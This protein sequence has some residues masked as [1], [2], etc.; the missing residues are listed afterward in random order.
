LY[1]NRPVNQKTEKRYQATTSSFF[2]KIDI[3][4]SYELEKTLFLGICP[5]KKSSNS[6]KRKKED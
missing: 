4:P 2:W 6:R 5:T 1:I 3:P